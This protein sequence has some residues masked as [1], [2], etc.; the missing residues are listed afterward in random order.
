MEDPVPRPRSPTQ[1]L[2]QT[3]IDAKRHLEELIHPPVEVPIETLPI[4]RMTEV[5]DDVE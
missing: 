5:G 4:I 2:S 1:F 3:F